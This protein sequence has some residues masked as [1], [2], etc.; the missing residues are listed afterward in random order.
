MGEKLYKPILRDGDH[1]V[2]SKKNEGRV[3]GVSQ[4]VNNNTTDIVEWEEVEIEE[5]DYNYEDKDQALQNVELTQEQQQFA[6][7]IG[8][9]IAAGIIYGAGKLNEH[10]IRPWWYNKAQPWINGKMS[11]VKRKFFCKTKTSKNSENKK[12]MSSQASM[13]IDVETNTQID[14]MMDQAFN[15]IQFDMSTKE[16]KMHIMNLIYHMLG[17]AYEIK[18]LSNSRIADEYEDENMRLKNQAKAEKFIAEKVA[19]NINHF[20]SDEQLQLDVFTSKQLFSLL[21]GGI[22]INEEYIPVE[23]EKIELAINSIKKENR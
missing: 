1:L 13:L 4:D 3:R 23:T 7:M 11:E 6:E 15:S 17:I 12:E 22:R 14:D 18:V 10:I 20:L 16:A 19:D 21:G 9:A 5:K 8:V 2:K